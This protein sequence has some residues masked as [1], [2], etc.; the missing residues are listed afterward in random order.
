MIETVAAQEYLAQDA[1]RFMRVNRTTDKLA[2]V[3]WLQAFFQN[4]QILFPA[5]SVVCPVTRTVRRLSMSSCSS[6][7]PS[8]TIFL[9]GF[10][11]WW[12]GR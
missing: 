12:K 8:M 3:Y 6:R 4:G 5:K 9:M 1:Q 11:R 10:R 2:R 7:R